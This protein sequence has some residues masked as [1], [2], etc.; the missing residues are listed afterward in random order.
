MDDYYCV[1]DGVNFPAGD[2]CDSNNDNW[3]ESTET[4]SVV[5]TKVCCCDANNDGEIVIDTACAS[6]TPYPV[7]QTIYDFGELCTELCPSS[8]VG[9]YELTVD[10]TGLGSNA[11]TVI[12]RK[13]GVDIGTK[14]LS[15]ATPLVFTLNEK[16]VAIVFTQDYCD[17]YVYPLENY[18]W[19]NDQASITVPFT[20]IQKKCVSSSNS[21]FNL[22]L[23]T[24]L[25]QPQGIMP[26]SARFDCRVNNKQGVV[27][28]T[29][30]YEWAITKGTSTIVNEDKISSTPYVSSMFK[31]FTGAS[32]EEGTFTITCTATSPTAVGDITLVD[33]LVITTE[34]P[35]CKWECQFDGKTCGQYYRCIASNW[36]ACGRDNQYDYPGVLPIVRCTGITKCN[37]NA[38]D[39][40]EECDGKLFKGTQTCATR[41]FEYGD[42]SC[43]SVCRVQTDDCF[44]CPT[45][46]SICTKDQC[47]KCSICRDAGLCY[48]D[49]QGC[50]DLAVLVD[51]V[52]SS[53]NDLILSW[54]TNFNECTDFKEDTYIIYRCDDSTASSCKV[55]TATKQIVLDTLDLNIQNALTYTDENIQEK[56]SYCYFIQAYLIST[57]DNRYQQTRTITSNVVCTE[58]GYDICM[59][60]PPQDEF[61]VTY[62]GQNVD[63]GTNGCSSGNNIR[64]ECN[65][66]QR[67]VPVK[68]QDW[69]C[70]NDRTCYDLTNEKT[71]CS[72]SFDCDYCGGLFNMYSY[73]TYT[74][75]LYIPY[76]TVDPSNGLSILSTIPCNDVQ[77]FRDQ[78]NKAQAPSC[79]ETKDK[80]TAELF[81]ECNDLA[82]CYDYTTKT[83]CEQSPCAKRLQCAWNDLGKTANDNILF[84]QGTQLGVCVPDN[85]KYTEDELTE[86][87]QCERCNTDKYIL[88][89]C[90]QELCQLYSPDKE[91][92]SYYCYFDGNNCLSSRN[93]ICSDY[94]T[95]EDCEGN[96]TRSVD[97]NVSY[98]DDQHY[99]RINGDNA[100][101]NSNDVV[102]L[103][104]CTWQTAVDDNSFCVRNADNYFYHETYYT[105]CLGM[106]DLKQCERDTTPPVTKLSL[107]KLFTD[108]NGH[109]EAVYSTKRFILPMAVQD[110]VYTTGL[111]T[112]FGFGEGENVAYPNI[113]L[114]ELTAQ[115][116]LSG[117]YTLSYYS[118]DPAKNLEKVRSEKII[119]DNEAPVLVGGKPQITR[120]EL[121]IPISVQGGNSIYL[122]N[123]SLALSFTD[124]HGPINCSFILSEEGTQNTWEDNTYAQSGTAFTLNYTYLFDGMYTLHYTCSDNPHLNNTLTG[125]YSFSLEADASIINPRP[126]YPNNIFTT[127][128]IT[129]S[130]DT[131]MNATCYFSTKQSD[132]F[133]EEGNSLYYAGHENITLFNTNNNRNHSYELTN[134]DNGVFIYYT[135]CNMTND[136]GKKFFTHQNLGD[137]IY[138]SIDRLAPNTTI[139]SNS[140]EYNP[141]DVEWANSRTF[142]LLCKDES[143][144][145]TTGAWNPNIGVDTIYYCLS[146]DK[147]HDAFS[148]APAT[149]ETSNGNAYLTKTFSHSEV[150]KSVYLHYYCVDK[151]GAKEEWK[152][153]HTKIRNLQFIVDIASVCYFDELG[154]EVC[155]PSQ[156]N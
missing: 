70:G 89:A 31:L 139:S 53:E 49:E 103:G 80:T 133:D 32:G 69:N 97:V 88:P 130:V 26:L 3:Q 66:E 111:T 6:G 86:V 33:S 128:D 106:E 148:C 92:D 145:Y 98:E 154:Y 10:V 24:N 146:A 112:Y 41:G 40:G 91:D 117:T 29:W 127:T 113:T 93:I 151:G 13:G 81:T 123:L 51:D 58:T 141:E 7:E 38:L 108:A 42:L 54:K 56:T 153:I 119:L 144:P 155:Q 45:S 134:L 72:A 1:D 152:T 102:G 50:N 94:D 18:I 47:Q 74:T 118:Q 116:I 28:S 126:S 138:F 132:F 142:N 99:V 17:D 95:Q 156:N 107:L 120:K 14:T 9:P 150:G 77:V 46:P 12:A 4:C 71:K 83:S 140:V 122:T 37:G 52:D 25:T 55:E 36:Q 135:A 114:E 149:T 75:P 5:S 100:K 59:T 96:P 44:S 90:T 8:S 121:Q 60:N 129:I 67:V 27:Q 79:Y 68:E 101:V 82:T 115:T 61:C 11:L 23:S 109:P 78:E 48:D 43:N 30:T 2:L 22:L 105:D 63:C 64:A 76:Q 62:N 35:L 20:E 136:E 110:N 147:E 124:E 143:L 16:P 131:L 85:T 15:T 34:R 84:G 65:S 21:E 57:S 125:E 137:W 73:L 19:T 87:V 104:V 39:E